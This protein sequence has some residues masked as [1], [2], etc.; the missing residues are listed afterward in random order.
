MLTLATLL[1]YEE[2]GTGTIVLIGL[3][4]LL[5][6]GAADFVLWTKVTPR[7]WS[8]YQRRLKPAVVVAKLARLKLQGSDGVTGQ[9]EIVVEG[10]SKEHPTPQ[11]QCLAAACTYQPIKGDNNAA[12][13]L[14]DPDMKCEKAQKNETTGTASTESDTDSESETRGSQAESQVAVSIM[15]IYIDQDNRGKYTSLALAS[16]YKVKSDISDD[17]IWTTQTTSTAQRSSRNCL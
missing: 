1:M 7:I 8:K 15:P 6:V 4:N 16:C 17:M 14:L 10:Y 9:P 12:M 11:K 5:V 2:T 13:T 3:L